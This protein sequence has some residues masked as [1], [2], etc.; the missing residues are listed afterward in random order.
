MWDY[1]FFGVRIAR[2]GHGRI[3]CAAV[4]RRHPL[5]PVKALRV[6]TVPGLRSTEQRCNG[7]SNETRQHAHGQ[8]KEGAKEIA[9]NNYY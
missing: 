6:Y 5:Q 4:K 7:V 8:E 9:D 1:T 3:S 2:S